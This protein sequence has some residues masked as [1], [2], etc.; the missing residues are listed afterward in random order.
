MRAD[1]LMPLL[2]AS[3]CLVFPPMGAGQGL[4]LGG[5]GLDSNPANARA[6]SD[7]QPDRFIEASWGMARHRSL[8]S[9]ALLLFR[10]S[11]QAEAYARHEKL[12]RLRLAM[13]G[14]ASFR[15]GDGFYAPLFTAWASAAYSEYGSRLRDGADYAAGLSLQ[16]PLTT[17]LSLRLGAQTS[18]REA[19]SGIFDTRGNTVQIDLEWSPAE[20]QRLYAGYQHHDGDLVTTSDAGPA[21]VRSEPDDAFGT[22]QRAFRLD[23][24]AGLGT[25][26]FSY[27]LGADWAADLQL[28]TV[29]AESSSGARYRRELLS[30][31]LLRRW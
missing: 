10:P 5:L 28:R 20:A 26:G 14:R 15:P 21:G 17:R 12:S 16:E 19:R 6:G 29:L 22:G 13:L 4:V 8:S 23:S 7:L 31:S 2:L 30:L 25:L 1:R 24:E 9:S 3:A 27:S 11:V 18:V